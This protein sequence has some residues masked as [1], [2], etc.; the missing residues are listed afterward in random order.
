[1][2]E[3]HVTYIKNY[4]ITNWRSRWNLLK[5]QVFPFDPWFQVVH[6]LPKKEI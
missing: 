3:K 2:Y 6:A 5:D 1:M 4:V